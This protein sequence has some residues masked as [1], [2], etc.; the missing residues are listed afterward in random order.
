M[1]V[2]K[3]IKKKKTPAENAC[4]CIEFRCVGIPSLFTGR[5][6]GSLGKVTASWLTIRPRLES[7]SVGSAGA[8]NIACV[9]SLCAFIYYC[10]ALLVYLVFL[11]FLQPF[12]DCRWLRK[13]QTAKKNMWVWFFSRIIFFRLLSKIQNCYQF[14][15]N[16]WAKWIRF[17]NSKLE[18][19]MCSDLPHA[20]AYSF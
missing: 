15:G 14:F 4:S 2:G 17:R 13:K 10:S 18:I 11:N 8:I 1:L 20:C 19:V 12:G 7:S 5:R 6:R 3:K 16:W 9:D